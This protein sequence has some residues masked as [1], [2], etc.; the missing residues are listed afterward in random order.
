MYVRSSARRTMMEK[1]AVAVTDARRAGGAVAE[2][3]DEHPTR[4]IPELCRLFYHMGWV[5]G[6]GGGIS[7]HKG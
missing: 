7:I 6:T 4:L 5:T 3:D 1:G 2:E